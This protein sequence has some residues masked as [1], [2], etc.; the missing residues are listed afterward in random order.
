MSVKLLIS[1]GK[2]SVTQL[3]KSQ[4]SSD[5]G[6]AAIPTPPALVL[7]GATAGPGGGTPG[8]RSRIRVFPTP[9]MICGSGMAQKKSRH[10]K[11]RD[12]VGGVALG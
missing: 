7:E 8:P 10:W 5:D 2:K 6:G 4:L 3:T 9:F 11:Y 12:G 1:W